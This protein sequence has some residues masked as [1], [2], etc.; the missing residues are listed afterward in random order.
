MVKVTLSVFWLEIVSTWL[1]FCLRRSLWDVQSTQ[2]IW[3]PK[4][5]S[6]T[7]LRLGELSVMNSLSGDV[8]RRFAITRPK[9]VFCD[10]NLAKLVQSSLREINVEP[11]IYT[12][13]G[14]V[15]GACPVEDLFIENGFE[16]EFMSVLKLLHWA[17]LK[18]DF[19]PDHQRW[20]M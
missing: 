10:A 20:K 2:W 19:L 8:S 15:D 5:V 14:V 17:G 13:G 9:V 3:C 4:N 16:R 18:N 7:S 6:V 11:K 1:R 12:F